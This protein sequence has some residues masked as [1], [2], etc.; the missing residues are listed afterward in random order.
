MT[1]NLNQINQFFSKLKL[2][3]TNNRP[4][5]IKIAGHLADNVEHNIESQ[6]AD[7]PGGWPSGKMFGGQ[8]LIGQGNLLRSIQSKAE[9]NEAMA[10]TNRVG[11]ALMN[12][13]GEV[14]AKKILGS[15]K[16]K[17]DVWGMEQ[18]FWRKWYESGEKEENW[19]ILALHM[20]KHNSITVKARLFMVLTD[21][22]MQKI[23]RTTEDYLTEV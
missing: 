22:Y 23:I 10:S 8:Q 1:D 4:L 19:R 21:L 17:R 15:V 7:V 14:K 6:G 5:M 16:R 2:K 18:F 13:G 20:M 9:E 11:A 3:S 12:F